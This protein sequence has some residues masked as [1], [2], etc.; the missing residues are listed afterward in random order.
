[1]ILED[2]K[3]GGGWNWQNWMR[4]SEQHGTARDREIS[5][6]LAEGWGWLMTH[7]LVVRNPSQSPRPTPTG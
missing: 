4:E 1:L 5:V 6:A 3:A 2:Y 7:G